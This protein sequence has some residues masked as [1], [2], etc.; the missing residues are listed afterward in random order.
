MAPPPAALPMVRQLYLCPHTRPV[1]PAQPS[2]AGSLLDALPGLHLSPEAVPQP[3]AEPAL[4]H[5]QEDAGRLHHQDQGEESGGVHGS[6][7]RDEAG[8]LC[9]GLPAPS[10]GAQSPSP[11]NP[12]SPP[13]CPVPKP[14]SPRTSPNTSFPNADPRSPATSALPSQSLIRPS[15]I[16]VSPK[17]PPQILTS[18]NTLSRNLPTPLPQ[19]FDPLRK[20][21]SPQ[22][23]RPPSTRPTR[24]SDPQKPLPKS[25]IRSP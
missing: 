11:Q 18:L 6:W 21:L 8:T 15:Q 16:L 20:S 13:Q 14:G 17:P 3:G 9:Q 7:A 23:L 22:I 1:A 12:S 5:A 2:P 24:G 25:P 19:I 10:G 4:L